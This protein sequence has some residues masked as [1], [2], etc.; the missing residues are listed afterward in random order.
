VP[1]V[2]VAESGEP[3]GLASDDLDGSLS[4]NEEADRARLLE[5]VLAVAGGDRIPVAAA[6][7]LIEFQLTRGLLG[8][9]T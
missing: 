4:G 2:Q 5:L 9:S 6:T 1:L 8:I 3:G 7:G